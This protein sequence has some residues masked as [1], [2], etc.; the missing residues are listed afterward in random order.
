MSQ[1]LRK[2][3]V[4]TLLLEEPIPHQ[5]IEEDTRPK[6]KNT[7]PWAKRIL[8]GSGVVSLVL[9]AAVT[10][11]AA[12]HLDDGTGDRTYHPTT[13]VEADHEYSFGIGS[14][15]VDLRD[16]DFPPG[17]HHVSVDLGIGSARVWLPADVNYDVTGDL[18]V[19]EIDLFGETHDGFGNELDAKTATDDATTV[20]V[21]LEVDIG[22]GQVRQG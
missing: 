18:D 9:A 11:V 3:D 10:A 7:S 16:V 20:I 13:W 5:P 1:R 21:D 14:L 4:M 19:G 6:D 22:Y 15:D 2:N 12:P 17:V 8:I